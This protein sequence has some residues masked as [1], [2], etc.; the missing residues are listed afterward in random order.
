MKT[1]IENL[2]N[3]KENETI[4]TE[5]VRLFMRK[6]NDLD[7]PNDL[8]MV[9]KE[10]FDVLIYDENEPEGIINTYVNKNQKAWFSVEYGVIKIRIGNNKQESSLAYYEEDF[11]MI[12]SIGY[13]VVK[14]ITEVYE[15]ILRIKDKGLIKDNLITVIKIIENTEVLTLDEVINFFDMRNDNNCKNIFKWLSEYRKEFKNV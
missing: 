9:S 12:G 3:R 13:N 10:T 8:K 6:F 11:D 2:N 14:A 1:I 5:E 15:K 7:L 4:I